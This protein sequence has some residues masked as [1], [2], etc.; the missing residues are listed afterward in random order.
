MENCNGSATPEATTPSS[1]EVPAT[2]EYLPYRGWWAPSN[3]WSVHQDQTLFMR[4]QVQACYDHTHYT[5]A[6]CVLRYLK[7]TSYYGLVM[8]VQPGEGV[9]VC[10]YS[11][12]D[13]ANDPVDRRS[14]GGYVTMLDNNVISYASRKQ[15]INSLSTCEAEY[16]AVAEATKDLI[17]LAGLCKELGWKHPVPLLLGDNQGAIALTAKP[18]KHSKSKHIDN[19]YHMVRRNVELK[20][21]PTQHVDTDVMTKALRVVKFTQFRTAY[22]Y[23]V[24][25]ARLLRWLLLLLRSDATS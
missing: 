16:V 21:F 15:E 23:W 8:D 7:A 1:V 24:K 11:D 12:A 22:H 19:K 13:Y 4:W 18:G 14:I 2:K 5:Q 3:T 20:R 10:A 17:W 9:E 25:T 6:N